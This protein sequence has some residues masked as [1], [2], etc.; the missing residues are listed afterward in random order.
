M[1]ETKKISAYLLIDEE[2]DYVATHDES[3]LEE[4]YDEHVCNGN[5]SRPR[6]IICVELQMAL[7]AVTTIYGE[8]PPEASPTNLTV[9]PS[10]QPGAQANG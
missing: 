6:R 4:L 1:A 2:G 5:S 8:I 7:P 9:L 10:P 3:L